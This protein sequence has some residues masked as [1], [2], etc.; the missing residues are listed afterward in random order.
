MVTKGE[1]DG[2]ASRLP[3]KFF[4]TLTKH[5]GT[6]PLTRLKHSLAL[7]HQFGCAFFTCEIENVLDNKKYLNKNS[8]VNFMT[9]LAV[10]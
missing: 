7:V 9:F 10:S 1:G 3:F 8:S 5:Q 2:I 6:L 4:S